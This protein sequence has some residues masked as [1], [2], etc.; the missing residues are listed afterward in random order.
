MQIKH[1]KFEKSGCFLQ[2]INEAGLY[3]TLID[4]LTHARKCAA[5]IEK[6]LLE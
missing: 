3:H 5:E 2:D 6:D 1:L 4:D